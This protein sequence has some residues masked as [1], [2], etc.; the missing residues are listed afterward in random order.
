[1]EK[2][3]HDVPTPSW[4]AEVKEALIKGIR[5][6]G[7]IAVLIWVSAEVFNY[8]T[9]RDE[10]SDPSLS[11]DAP[12]PSPVVISPHQDQ[13]DD[14]MRQSALAA[15]VAVGDG[16]ATEGHQPTGTKP[17]YDAGLVKE[18]QAYVKATDTVVAGLDGSD[19]A[20]L[21]IRPHSLWGIALKERAQV[22]IGSGSAAERMASPYTSCHRAAY[23][24]SE[25]WLS[26]LSFA[27]RP[28]QDGYS[29][30]QRF[31]KHYSETMTECESAGRPSH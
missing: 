21:S 15:F 7:V 19:R 27:K 8:L 9:G 24:A 29:Q 16:N 3:N 26:R 20:A 18:I 11:E 6:L 22:F 12:Q 5:R 17:Q 2:T 31:I 10:A 13:L 30:L 28:T 14:A 23:Y 25:V 1:M 4:K